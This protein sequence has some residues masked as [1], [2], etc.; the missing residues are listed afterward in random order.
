M[1]NKLSWV[2]RQPSTIELNIIL[3]EVHRIYQPCKPSSLIGTDIS[4]LSRESENTVSAVL[5]FKKQIDD[6]NKARDWFPFVTSDNRTANICWIS[7]D[8]RLKTRWGKC[9]FETG[10][11]VYILSRTVCFTCWLTSTFYTTSF[12]AHL[13]WDSCITYRN[14]KRYN[15]ASSPQTEL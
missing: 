10:H 8:Y 14:S 9:P 11:N 13:I 12:W 2:F 6:C 5:C 4:R 7:G 3:T 15:K 1:G